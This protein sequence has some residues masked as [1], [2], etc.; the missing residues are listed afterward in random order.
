[1]RKAKGG[2]ELWFLFLKSKCKGMILIQSLKEIE[3]VKIAVKDLNKK[4][5]F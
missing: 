3:I 5:G 2:H 4:N 1:M